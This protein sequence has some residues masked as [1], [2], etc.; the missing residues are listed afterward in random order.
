[1]L[2]LWQFMEIWKTFTPFLFLF[3]IQE[4][5]IMPLTNMLLILMHALSDKTE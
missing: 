3:L 1:M 2:F 4:T 5:E